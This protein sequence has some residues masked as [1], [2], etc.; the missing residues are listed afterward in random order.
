M[1]EDRIGRRRRKMYL[2]PDTGSKYRDENHKDL[3]CDL[4]H[5]RSNSDELDDGECNGAHL[6]SDVGVHLALIS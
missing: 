5:H 4:R 3:P 2:V 6:V 1:E